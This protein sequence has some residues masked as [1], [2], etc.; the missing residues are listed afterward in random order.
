MMLSLPIVIASTSGFRPSSSI[1]GQHPY[2]RKRY[3]VSRSTMTADDDQRRSEIVRELRR[4]LALPEWSNLR[5]DDVIALTLAL[6]G[7][8]RVHVNNLFVELREI[9]D[10]TPR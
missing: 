8:T 2:A 9:D 7:E 1:R 4:L 5:G 3:H 10:G 6:D